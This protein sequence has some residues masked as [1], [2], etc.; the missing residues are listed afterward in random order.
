MSWSLIQSAG[1]DGT[2]SLGVASLS[3]AYPS[4]VTGGNLLVVAVGAFGAIT[5]VSDTRS[6][7][8]HALIT[9]VGGTS[10]FAAIFW[11]ISKDSGP[12]TATVTGGSFLPGIAVLEFAAPGSIAIDGWAAAGA[13]TASAATPAILLNA[14]DLVVGAIGSDGNPALSAGT[15]YTAA[16]TSAGG[17]GA[18]AS[19]AIYWANNANATASPAWTLSTSKRSAFV[20]VAFTAI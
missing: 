11:A 4:D 6:N 13:T 20:G 7:I 1:V 14:T 10:T 9:S 2:N 17:S 15:G 12:C 19:C 18:E 8:W 5:G 3:E 16:Y